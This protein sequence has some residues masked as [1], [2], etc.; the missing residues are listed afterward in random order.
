MKIILCNKTNNRKQL[1]LYIN[2]MP[3][4]LSMTVEYPINSYQYSVLL[5]CEGNRLFYFYL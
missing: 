4:F 1:S 3:I 2:K 5:G